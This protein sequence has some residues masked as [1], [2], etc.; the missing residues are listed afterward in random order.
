MKFLTTFFGAIVLFISTNN[1]DII[2][3]NNLEDTKID[4]VVFDGN[5]YIFLQK[6]LVINTNL[7][8]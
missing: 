4:N 7:I 1:L 2:N 3:V 6:E 5:E 8:Q